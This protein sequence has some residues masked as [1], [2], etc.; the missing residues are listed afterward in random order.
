MA[1]RINVFIMNYLKVATKVSKVILFYFF[2]IEDE[3]FC[4]L[5]LRLTDL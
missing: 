3:D 1:G 5:K 4:E 2:I